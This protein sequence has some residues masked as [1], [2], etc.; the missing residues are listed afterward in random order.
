MCVSACARI[1]AHALLPPAAISY[2]S[3]L[4]R[5]ASKSGIFSDT[6]QEKDALLTRKIN[7]EAPDRAGEEEGED[8]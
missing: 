3:P 4:K 1:C 6:L 5:I 2:K 8:Q 7:T